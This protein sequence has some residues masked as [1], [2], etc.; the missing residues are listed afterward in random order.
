MK[1]VQTLLNLHCTGGTWSASIQEGSKNQKWLRKAWIIRDGG[2][3]NVCEVW[4]LFANW[5]E[6]IALSLQ[7][8]LQPLRSGRP[9]AARYPRQGAGRVHKGLHYR[10]KG[11]CTPASPS[12]G[13][14]VLDLLL[15][16]HAWPPQLLDGTLEVG[17]DHADGKV[18]RLRVSAP[19]LL[20]TLLCLLG[21]VMEGIVASLFGSIVTKVAWGHHQPGLPPRASDPRVGGRAPPSCAY[22][23]LWPPQ[24][25]YLHATEYPRDANRD[26]HDRGHVY[27]KERGMEGAQRRH[28][29]LLHCAGI[30]LRPWLIPAITLPLYLERSIMFTPIHCPFDFW[31]WPFPETLKIPNLIKQ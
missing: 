7:E 28:R 18:L 5:R 2:G 20:Q 30:P 16:G 25:A 31:Q 1:K 17:T 27:G 10:E 12:G 26:S 11:R 22:L 24:L 21:C 9:G 19:G 14:A 6:A 13:P 15:A 8:S 29:G 3:R 4:G 23:L